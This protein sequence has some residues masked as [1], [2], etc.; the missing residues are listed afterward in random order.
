MVSSTNNNAVASSELAIRVNVRY[1][2][3]PE[4]KIKDALELF[5]SP[6]WVQFIV[7]YIM[8]QLNNA[9]P[10]AVSVL[11]KLIKSTATTTCCSEHC[12]VCMEQ[13]KKDV[14]KL[15]CG[16]SFHSSC[17]IPWL[18]VHSTCPTCRHQLPTD[19]GTLY[20]VQA[21][22]TTIVLGK[23][24]AS[25]PTDELLELDAGNQTIQAVVNA[26]VR[27][28][29]DVSTQQQPSVL[30]PQAS[31]ASTTAIVEPL[32]PS[33]AAVTRRHNTRRRRSSVIQTP[34]EVR[35]SMQMM[36]ASMEEIDY[37]SRKR[38]RRNPPR[39]ARNTRV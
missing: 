39:Q 5:R 18:K 35:N 8:P 20:S 10:A 4:S 26:R 11:Q 33:T 34:E 25:I 6:S 38:Q 22:N 31:D 2:A 13:I 23:S 17:L 28:N 3:P 19:A 29:V 7:R 9:S 1:V 27:R 30:L 24:Q 21:I 15:P 36:G 32:T 14:A 37:Q 16:H 12:V